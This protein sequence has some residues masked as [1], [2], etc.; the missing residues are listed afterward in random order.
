MLIR[1]LHLT[2]KIG[3]HINYKKLQK[4][5]KQR[6]Y[7]N[8]LDAF[9][10]QKYVMEVNKNR[11]L[12]KKIQIPNKKSNSSQDQTSN[13]CSGKFTKQRKQTKLPIPKMKEFH[14]FSRFRFEI[15][16]GK[17][18]KVRCVYPKIYLK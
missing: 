18:F 1:C 17:V 4:N 15:K 16:K 12:I 13:Y 3:P 14:N 9:I 10:N 5:E 2:Y 8:V 7:G 6:I 11:K